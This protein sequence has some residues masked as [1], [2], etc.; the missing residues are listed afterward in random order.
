MPADGEKKAGVVDGRLTAAATTWF[1]RMRSD[2]KTPEDERCFRA[3]LDAD[4]RHAAVYGGIQKTWDAL[5]AIA[6]TPE[7]QAMRRQT[8]QRGAFHAGVTRPKRAILPWRVTR[9]LAATVFLTVA[10]AAVLFVSVTEQ[11]NPA[12]RTAAGER[13]TVTLDDG[14]LVTLTSRSWLVAAF[15]PGERRVQLKRGE[16]FFD[17]AHRAE[18]PF[19]VEAGSGDVTALGT[20]FDVYNRKNGEIVVT[21]IDGKV[22]VAAHSVQK[23][24]VP[25][26]VRL[27]PGERV[28]YDERGLSDVGTV[29]LARAVAWREGR[30]FVENEPLEKVVAEINRHSKRK[31]RFDGR[32]SQLRR[33][34]VSGVFRTDRPETLIAFLKDAGIPVWEVKDSQGNITLYLRPGARRG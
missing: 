25:S 7:L 24:G 12:Y 31:I 2:E 33:I 1:A 28:S 26:K 10:A 15:T 20:K 14:T 8:L 27:S 18:R 17:V 30:I 3:W 29:D 13:R 34:P 32:S 19:V 11:P 4:S 22:E 9:A 21:L 6:D 16:A 5:S 23:K